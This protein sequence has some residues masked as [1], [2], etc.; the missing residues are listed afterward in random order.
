M[1]ATTQ[2]A[3]KAPKPASVLASALC[4]SRMPLCSDWAAMTVLIYRMS[5]EQQLKR[6][7]SSKA[8]GNM[9]LQC[10]DNECCALARITEAKHIVRWGEWRLN[11]GAREGRL[12]YRMIHDRACRCIVDAGSEGYELHRRQRYVLEGQDLQGSSTLAARGWSWDEAGDSNA[13][14]DWWRTLCMPD[15]R[16]VRLDVG[17]S[18]KW[19]ESA[20]AI[21]VDT[22]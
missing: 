15:A 10:R 16:L 21:H 17:I 6:N 9:R 8:N 18:S 4:R 7:A 1:S 5:P 11:T 12:A 14:H 2:D 20:P 3:A 19:R 13:T 22:R